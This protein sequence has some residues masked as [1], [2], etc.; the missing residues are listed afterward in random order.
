MTAACGIDFG[1][2]NSAVAMAGAGAAPG[3][4]ARLIPLQGTATSVPTALFFSFEDATTTYGREAMV[5]YLE[6]EEG[7][8]LRSIK[9]LLGTSLYEEM[10]QVKFRRYAFAEIIADSCARRRQKSWATRQIRLSSAGPPSSS[11]TTRNPMR[12]PSPSSNR[13]RGRRA[14][15]PSN[16]SSSRSRRPCTTSRA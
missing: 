16:S 4:R 13:R 7:R 11:M 5:R 3:G 12:S 1:T 10:T 6:R 2:S 15:R 8:L 9:S 14:S